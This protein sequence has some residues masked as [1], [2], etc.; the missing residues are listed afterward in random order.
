MKAETRA[1]ERVI[2]VS[3]DCHAGPERY[4]D[5]EQYTPAALRPDLCRYIS[6]IE[7]FE[8]SAAEADGAGGRGGAKSR[9]DVGLWDM[10]LRT[11]PQLEDSD[12]R[13]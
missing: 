1:D 5:Y 4:A 6:C 2:V 12:Q 7:A 8:A 10:S 11:S 3:A 13:G 9:E